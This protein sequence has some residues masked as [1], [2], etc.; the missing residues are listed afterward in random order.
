MD[1]IDDIFNSDLTSDSKL[2][3]Q[4]LCLYLNYDP[5]KIFISKINDSLW[6]C[7]IVINKLNKKIII[8]ENINTTLKKSESNA[9]IT[10]I[11][12]LKFLHYNKKY[13][14]NITSPQILNYPSP[15]LIFK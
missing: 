12:K 7:Q 14:N 3:L 4:Q 2:Q 10:V 9:A 5:P 11:N 8:E 15:D 6:K 1:K 13:A